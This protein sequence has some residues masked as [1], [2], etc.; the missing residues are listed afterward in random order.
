[1]KVESVY[2]SE[3]GAKE[4]DEN[5]FKVIEILVHIASR[6]VSTNIGLPV[7]RQF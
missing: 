2:V 7:N 5:L 4:T 3:S 1:M 6:S